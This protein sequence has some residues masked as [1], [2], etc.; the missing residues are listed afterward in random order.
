MTP[1]EQSEKAC[2]ILSNEAFHKELGVWGQRI[3]RQTRELLHAKLSVM[4]FMKLAACIYRKFHTA[5]Q[6]QGYDAGVVAAQLAGGRDLTLVQ[7]EDDEHAKQQ[8]ETR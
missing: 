6:A 5:A 8:K 4:L 7:T 1:T 2:G 3:H